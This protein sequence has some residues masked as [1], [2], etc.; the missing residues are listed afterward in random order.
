MNMKVM[1]KIAGLLVISAIIGTNLN[2]Q[3]RNDVIKA[4]NEGAS[5]MQTDIPAAIKAFENVVTLSDQVGETANDLKQKAVQVLPGLYL[6]YANSTLKEKK[7]A[8]EIIKAAKA[9][10]AAAEKYGSA[11]TKENAGKILLQGYYNMGTDFFT[12]KDYENA[13][14]AFDSLY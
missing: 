11:S 2:A 12:R 9:A 14:L 5:S 13:L 10:S 4:Y 3:A 8:P 6:K 1:R 7:P